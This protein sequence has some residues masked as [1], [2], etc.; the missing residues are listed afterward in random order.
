MLFDKW[1]VISQHWA[2]RWIAV[3]PHITQNKPQ[4][5]DNFET[6]ADTGEIVVSV[7][8]PRQ[9]AGAYLP[10]ANIIFRFFLY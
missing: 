4:Q 1:F 5:I 6:R 10:P 3:K 7:N 2:K 8:P 9:K